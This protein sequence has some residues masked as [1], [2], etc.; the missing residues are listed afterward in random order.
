[1][2]S[3]LEFL[4]LARATI[5]PEVMAANIN[6]KKAIHHSDRIPKKIPRAAPKAAPEDIPKVKGEARGFLK[7]AWAR[8]PLAAKPA[9][10]K[11]P[12]ATLGSLRRRKIFLS[13]GSSQTEE[14]LSPKCPVQ[15]DRKALIAAKTTKQRR[16]RRLR[17]TIFSKVG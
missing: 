9:P 10:T 16:I 6:D 1:M 5:P 3:G 17:Q 12:A 4:N 8:T 7:I 2:V 13:K 14:K 15:R 11:I